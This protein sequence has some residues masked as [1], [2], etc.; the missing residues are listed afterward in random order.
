MSKARVWITDILQEQQ[1]QIDDKLMDLEAKIQDMN[2]KVAY[3]DKNSIHACETL[4]KYNRIVYD[5]Q[6]IELFKKQFQLYKT[7]SYRIAFDN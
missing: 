3:M 1:K 5:I 6:L 7:M 2:N 4:E